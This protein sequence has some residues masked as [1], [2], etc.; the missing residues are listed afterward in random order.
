MHCDQRCW[1]AVVITPTEIALVV[2]LTETSGSGP[3]THSSSSCGCANTLGRQGTI[4]AVNGYC[5][6]FVFVCALVAGSPKV[7]VE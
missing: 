1:R 6:L 2:K 4:C 5:C 3:I 7:A